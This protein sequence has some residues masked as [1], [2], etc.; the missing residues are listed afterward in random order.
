MTEQQSVI[1]KIAVFDCCE[2]KKRFQKAFFFVY[3]FL[4]K[5]LC[6]SPTKPEEYQNQQSA[7]FALLVYLLD[8]YLLDA[9]SDRIE[10]RRMLQQAIQCLMI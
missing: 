8:A 1:I 7:C 10:G 6:F 2:S 9:S 4:E 3:V 5:P